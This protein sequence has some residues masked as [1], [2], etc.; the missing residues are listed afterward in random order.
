M[1][2]KTVMTAFMRG[3]V[4]LAA[5]ALMAAGALAN[6]QSGTP[7]STG[8][9]ATGANDSAGDCD[10]IT[11]GS[12]YIPVDSWV[13]PAMLRLYALGYVDTVYLGMRPWTRVSLSRMLDETEARLEDVDEGPTA[14][15]AEGL[16]E[17]LRREVRDDAWDSCM[18]TK[19]HRPRRVGLHRMR[20][21]SAARRC[22]TATILV[23]PS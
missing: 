23:R 16:Y 12:P 17:A 9:P 14:N 22:A 6:G 4:A 2:K 15:E 8:Q 18:R 3:A 1:H 13:Y 5:L 11:R 10:P 20:A 19:G 21:A 7:G